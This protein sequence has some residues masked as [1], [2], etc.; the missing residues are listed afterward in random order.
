MLGRLARAA[1]GDTSKNQRVMAAIC[2]TPELRNLARNG[3]PPAIPAYS[4]TSLWRN[5]AVCLQQL[6]AAD[7]SLDVLKVGITWTE[8]PGGGSRVDLDMSVSRRSPLHFGCPTGM[9]L[10]FVEV[11][12]LSDHD[13]HPVGRRFKLGVP[14]PLLV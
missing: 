13:L 14:G 3:L 10:H 2:L 11:L 9:L 1:T 7:E 12:V 8:A 5:E 6:A 4:R